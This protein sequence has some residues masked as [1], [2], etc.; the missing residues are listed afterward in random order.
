MKFD[1]FFKSPSPSLLHRQEGPISTCLGK[2]TRNCWCLVIKMSFPQQL[3]YPFE[4]QQIQAEQLA[5]WCNAQTHDSAVPGASNPVAI[6]QGQ[7]TFQ[8]PTPSSQTQGRKPR[9]VPC[10][11]C[12]KARRKVRGN[13]LPEG[14]LA[15][16]LCESV[17]K[18][19]D[20]PSDTVCVVH[21]SRPSLRNGECKANF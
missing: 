19:A 18:A 11:I 16:D 10:K 8:A 12:R 4:G 1:R 5:A 9:P 15:H 6:Q 20:D 3:N 13:E 2:S 17:L 14:G 7:V 21:R